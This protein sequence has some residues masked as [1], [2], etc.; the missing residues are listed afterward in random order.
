MLNKMRN[1]QGFT[2]IEL[3]IVVA[4]IGILAAIA[5]PQFA[6]YRTR[7]FNAS[8]QSDIRGLATSQAALFGDANIFGVSIATSSAVNPLVFVG[9]VGGAGALL[10]GPNGA[11]GAFVPSI[12]GTDA[13]AAKRGIQIPLGNNV[14]LVATTNQA[15]AAAGLVANATFTAASKHVQGNTVFGMDGDSTAVYQAA[16][17][18][19]EGSALI[20]ANAPASTSGDDFQITPAVTVGTKAGTWTAK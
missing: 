5:I 6:A 9:S 13:N 18:G 10:L 19:T 11:A 17:A 3:L 20:V 15:D 14:Y 16:I 12:T 7:G 2:L 1:R 8:G 4:I